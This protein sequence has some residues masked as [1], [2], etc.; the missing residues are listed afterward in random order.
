MTFVIVSQ[1]T[2]DFVADGLSP[3]GDLIAVYLLPSL[4]A[5][6]HSLVSCLHAGNVCDI[7]HAQVHTDPSTNRCTLSAN[8][9]RGPVGESAQVPIAVPDRENRQPRVPIHIMEF[10]SSAKQCPSMA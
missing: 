7:G 1:G 6:Q 2:E 5:E 3:T 8:Q 4:S 9:D 10:A